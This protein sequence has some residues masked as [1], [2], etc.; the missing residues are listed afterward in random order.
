MADAE[1]R[2][3]A[4]EDP[5]QVFADLEEQGRSERRVPENHVAALSGYRGAVTWL[6]R[7]AED[8]G[9]NVGSLRSLR[10]V[11]TYPVIKAA[12][13]DQVARSHAASDL[14]DPVASDT[15]KGRLTSLRTLA[16]YGLRDDAL[17]RL[18][19]GQ[20]RLSVTLPRSKVRA[21]DLDAEQMDADVIAALLR[22]HPH[23]AVTL[24]NAPERLATAADGLLARAA[25]RRAEDEALRL[26]GAAAA[27]ALQMSRPLRTSNL[28]NVRLRALPEVPS[29]LTWLDK[30]RTSARLHFRAGEVKNATAV[31]ARIVGPDATIL[32]RWV[33]E[34]RPRLMTLRS[35]DE[36]NVYLFPG[37]A[38]PDELPGLVLPRGALAP[39]SFNGLWHLGG[40]RLGV[41]FGAHRARHAVATLILA[42]RPGDYSL[43]ASVLGDWEGTVRRHYGRDSGEAASAQ[44]RE[45]L[46]RQHPDLMRAARRRYD[47]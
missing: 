8:R 35:L 37:E 16:R 42:M 9:T 34:V 38:L 3:A 10:E 28:R 33:E 29:N 40:E 5:G 24:V 20:T 43:V 31:A 44:V 14:K 46:L 21:A 39:S 18:I 2:I 4:G 41:R 30:R 23:L 17:V 11:M 36:D 26:Y 27:W 19:D 13:D 1:A 6:V 22:G 7:A 47:E 32:G 25:S 12:T 15:L 45:E